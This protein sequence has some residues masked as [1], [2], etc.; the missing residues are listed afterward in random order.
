MEKIMEILADAGLKPVD[1]FVRNGEAYFLFDTEDDVRS[2]APTLAEH[3][4]GHNVYIDRDVTPHIAAVVTDKVPVERTAKKDDDDEEVDDDATDTDAT[5]DFSDDDLDKLEFGASVNDDDDDDDYADII[6]AFADDDDDDDSEELTSKEV[7]EIV[8]FFGDGD[9]AFDE[10][11][12]LIEAEADETMYFAIGDT[13]ADSNGNTVVVASIDAD[14]E[15]IGV[16]ERNDEGEEL[17]RGATTADVLV[18]LLAHERRFKVPT[19]IVAELNSLEADLREASMDDEADEVNAMIQEIGGAVNLLPKPTVIDPNRPSQGVGGPEGR[20]VDFGGSYGS[21]GMDVAKVLKT[22]GFKCKKGEGGT[23]TAENDDM[24]L[25][26]SVCKKGMKAESKPKTA[27]RGKHPLSKIIEF[28][29]PDELEAFVES[30]GYTKTASVF[31]VNPDEIEVESAADVNL[32][33][34]EQGD[35]PFWN[36]IISGMPVARIHLQDQVKHSEIASMFVT[37][38]FASSLREAMV[39]MGAYEML[40][41]HNARFYAAKV[42]ESEIA[43]GLEAQM[44]DTY[45]AKF[46]ELRDNWRESFANTARVAMAGLSK[47]WWRDDAHPLKE[48]LFHELS[49]RGVRDKT[50]IIEAAFE[51][52]ADDMVASVIKRTYELMDMEPEAYKQV[53]AH[54]VEGSVIMVDEPEDA[55]F[56]EGFSKRLKQGNVPVRSGAAV[57]GDF[58][59]R[60]AQAVRNLRNRHRGRL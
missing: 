23:M 7:N 11:D 54:I 33:L 18:E 29:T 24:K 56:G 40:D 5:D 36:V 9:T 49:E 4:E 43:T 2:A 15:E 10:D 12:M 19:D 32:V 30:M 28:E 42:V 50:A 52:G 16:I 13:F 39:R 41:H 47:N 46:D 8:A 57:E 53:A 31:L 27:A 48:A 55:N 3:Y 17:D 38:T 45:S 51:S 58:T 14:T 1:A 44:E 22:Y 6:A 34:H 35:N 26:V 60:T 37:D 25:M 20:P 21:A 59:T